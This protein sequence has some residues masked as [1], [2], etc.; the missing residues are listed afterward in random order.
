MNKLMN[1]NRNFNEYRDMMRLVTAP[2]VPFFGVYLTDLTFVE[3][4]NPDFLQGD[5][6]MINFSKR[7]K[8]ADIIREIQ[9]YQSLP[10]VFHDVDDIQ[11]YLTAGFDSAP[12]ID[13]QYQLSLTLEP[14]EIPGIAHDLNGK[15][16]RRG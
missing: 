4:G 5:S 12:S 16:F 8:I 1:S 7:V 11:S 14:R 9:Q 13:E 3:N 2:C 6:Q 15:P 10:Y